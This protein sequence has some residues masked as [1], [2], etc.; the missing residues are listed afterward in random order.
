MK[1]QTSNYRIATYAFL[2]ALMMLL[3]SQF[4][5]VNA[6][7]ATGAAADLNLSAEKQA[8]ESFGNDLLPYIEQENRLRKK[9]TLTSAELAALRASGNALKQRIATAQQNF[10]SLIAKLKAANQ[11]DTLDTQVTALITDGSL[12][13][14]LQ[15]EGGA[16]KI[17]EEL[18]NEL[19][20]LA[21]EIDGDVQRLSSRLQS[22]SSSPE[23][24]LRSRAVRVAY[25]PTLVVKKSLKCRVAIAVVTIKTFVGQRRP[26]AAEGQQMREACGNATTV[27]L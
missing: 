23:G 15:D 5:G 12:R 16:K 24:D 21:Q 9:A 26:T 6:H 22:Q 7:P 3:P 19:G 14:L 20:S 1:T 4:P 2:M 10:R 25:Q 27:T 8:L 18:A 17:W 13:S 11:W